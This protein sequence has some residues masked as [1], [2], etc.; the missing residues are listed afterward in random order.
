MLCT[1][2]RQA[3]TLIELLVVIAIV[4]FLFLFA[5]AP[6]TFYSNTS[7]VRLSV[8]RVEQEMSKAKLLV[9]T[10]FA[11]NGA[12]VDLVLRIRQGTSSITLDSIPVSAS[13]SAPLPLGDLQR[14]S[15]NRVPLDAPVLI[16]GFIPSGG[17]PTTP[18]TS[19][20]IIDIVYR[21]PNGSMEVWD[22][23]SAV[24]TRIISDIQGVVGVKGTM[25]GSLSRSFML[26]K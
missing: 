4:G 14:K 23:S 21:S 16:S 19:I 25:T 13:G 2:G 11:P 15:I 17:T 6:Y 12:N 18:P 22:S 3:F 9:S 20:D 1:Q 24:S 8:D 5:I 7:K 26:R 10:G